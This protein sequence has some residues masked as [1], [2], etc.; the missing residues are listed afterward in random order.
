MAC[1]E[2]QEYAIKKECPVTCNNFD[3]VGLPDYDCGALQV[4]EGCF[5]LE[6]FVMDTLGNCITKDK[7]GCSLP[8]QSTTLQVCKSMS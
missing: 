8:D 4:V 2:N 6:G 3:K 1:G 7:C 5:C